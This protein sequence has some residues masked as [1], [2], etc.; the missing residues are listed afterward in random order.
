MLLVEGATYSREEW[1]ALLKCSSGVLDELIDRKIFERLVEGKWTLRFVGTLV[2]AELA[3]VCVPKIASEEFSP[4][5][6]ADLASYDR[7]SRI[8][9]IY[10]ERSTSRKAGHDKIATEI[11]AEGA[12]STPLRE[13]EL[14][15]ALVSWTA[16]YGYHSVETSHRSSGFD[17]PI[18]WTETLAGCIP[19]HSR[20]GTIY[21]APICVETIHKPTSLTFCQARFLTTLFA[22]YRRAVPSL[23][24]GAYELL[25]EGFRLSDEYAHGKNLSTA[26]LT[27]LLNSTNRDHE[28]DLVVI[29][30]GL[31]RIEEA[32]HSKHNPVTLYGTTAFE[33]VWEDMCREVFANNEEQS[34]TLANPLYLISGSNRAVSSQRPDSICFEQGKIFILDAK[35]YV[36]FPKT[37]APALEDIRKQIF[38]VL[39]SNHGNEACAAFL[40]PYSLGRE[41]KYLGHAA[42]HIAID[43]D[44]VAID[45]RF[46]PVHCLGLPWIE[47]V[48]CY[49]GRKANR[50]IRNV[51]LSMILSA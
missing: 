9:E 5:V 44:K 28:K 36:G 3:W 1:I 47:M 37:S 7:L 50:D 8:L 43:A 16:T 21:N 51:A 25:D 15:G 41:V 17:K 4:S 2:F 10:A 19:V 49:L 33:Y 26:D 20:T 45:E 35:Y 38:Y 39:S 42:M 18:N 11:I 27:E 40:F 23:I 22:K 12:A 48:N 32:R 29:L 24:R 13:L 30:L 46:P 31:T 34:L 6:G 14:F